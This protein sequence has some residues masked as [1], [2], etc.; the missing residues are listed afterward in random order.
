MS[1]KLKLSDFCP[2]I[3]KEVLSYKGFTVTVRHELIP[4]RKL[5]MLEDL[6]YLVTLFRYMPTEEICIVSI[7]DDDA[8][9][10]STNVSAEQWVKEEN[11]TAV[12]EKLYRYAKERPF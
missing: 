1:H 4:K 8:Y 2:D 11:Q 6:L 3:F 5:S 12:L 7:W 9:V 10:I